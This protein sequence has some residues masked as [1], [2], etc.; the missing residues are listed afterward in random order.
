MSIGMD[1]MSGSVYIW[2]CSK[3]QTMEGC[4]GPKFEKV[5]AGGEWV[6]QCK[7]SGGNSRVDNVDGE[8]ERSASDQILVNSWNCHR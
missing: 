1:R 4:C 3:S 8:C 6:R 5:N 7:G 2:D